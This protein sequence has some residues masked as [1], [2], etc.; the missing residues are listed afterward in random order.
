MSYQVT[1][2]AY[3][4]VCHCVSSST[5]NCS[6]A[7]F[8]LMCC[9]LKMNPQGFPL[10]SLLPEQ[11]SNAHLNFCQCKYQFTSPDEV[12]AARRCHSQHFY[13][14]PHFL[15]VKECQENSRMYQYFICAIWLL[16]LFIQVFPLKYLIQG[17]SRRKGNT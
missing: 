17:H 3:S 2:L 16:L 12:C 9:R 5:Q 15:V 14:E 7:L 4:V 13:Y 8:F 10:L 6:R 11:Q 1:T